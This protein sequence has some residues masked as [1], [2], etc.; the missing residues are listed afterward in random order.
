MS[1]VI[2]RLLMIDGVLPR[3]NDELRDIEMASDGDG[4]DALY[5][6][7]RFVHPTLT[8]ERLEV[9]I[10]TQGVSDS[11][12]SHVKNSRQTIENEAIRGWV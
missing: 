1:N 10:P 4:Y 6:I 5:N 7:L 2:Y 8:D 12:A 9:K 11:F 3:N